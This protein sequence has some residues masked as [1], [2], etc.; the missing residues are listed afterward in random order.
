MQVYH[1][2]EMPYPD[3]WEGRS[4]LRVDIPSELYDPSH[5]ADLYERHFDEWA[6]CDELGI[7]I[8]VNEHHATAT[9]VVPSCSIPLAILARITKKVRLLA[10]GVP[11][12]NRANPVRIAEEM[13]MIDVISRGRLD[14]GLVRGSPY[15]IAVANARPVG[16][17]ERFWEAH[18]LLLKALTT[19]DG[20]FSWESENYHYRKVNVWPRPYQD[21]H[22]PVWITATSPTSAPRIADHRY[23]VATLL[24]GVIARDLFKAYRDHAA[25]AGWTPDV[26]R[27]AYC[28]IV[29]VGETEA[30][31]LRR[32]DQI[33]D[34]FRTSPIV[35][36][37]F[38][39]PPGYKKVPAEVASLKAGP[40][41]GRPLVTPE[42]RRIDQKTA[43]I[44]DFVD[45]CSVF[46]GTPDQV[47]DQ[48]ARFYDFTGGF[49]HLLMMGQ[50]GHLSH[51]DT[52]ANLTLFAEEVQPR[53]PELHQRGLQT[54]AI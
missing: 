27:F 41:A 24:S 35:A 23:I 25:A 39:N 12:A 54:R 50:G 10:L 26:D 40:N 19:S 5:G 49:G 7:N 47:Y 53:L 48:I 29:G 30:E 20:P 13:A 3:V 16:Q 18:D 43:K 6:L 17:M 42:G 22:P 8:M 15:E 34:Y 1:F 33:A 28:G 11:I 14:L 36:R 2:S 52:V 9:C 51:A 45:A 4:S 38:S 46:A 32:A 44:E 31:G 37:E 21:P